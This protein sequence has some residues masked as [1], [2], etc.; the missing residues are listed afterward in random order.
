M[1][2]AGR[3]GPSTLPGRDQEFGVHMPT[4]S[5]PPALPLEPADRSCGSNEQL[6][7]TSEVLASASQRNAGFRRSFGAISLHGREAW[8]LTPKVARPGRGE[9]FAI[10]Q[11]PRRSRR[12]IPVSFAPLSLTDNSPVSS[13]LA[14][15]RHTR[16]YAFNAVHSSP[17]P[18]F[19]IHDD[20]RTN[21]HCATSRIP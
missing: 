2:S 8:N 9:S 10:L 12:P 5:H 14:Q 7:P 1:P 21:Q 20:R 15:P 4:H 17:H 6:Y 3:P 16:S 13:I 11:L 18:S 19:I